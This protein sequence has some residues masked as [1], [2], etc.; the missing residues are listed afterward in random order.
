M[1][2]FAKYEKKSTGSSSLVGKGLVI[3]DCKYPDLSEAAKIQ[4]ER[5]GGELTHHQI[6]LK[7]FLEKSNDPLK[8]NFKVAELN[9]KIIGLGKSEYIIPPENAPQ[10]CIPEGWYLSGVIVSPG[11]RRLGIGLELTKARIDWLFRKTDTVYYFANSKNKVSIELHTKLGFKE[12]ARNIWAPGL[13][14]DGVHI[15]YFLTNLL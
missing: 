6:K 5:E 9:K 12:N 15:L 7:A 3:R 10:N 11:Y 13:S 1:S 14:G 8:A 4:C 2:F